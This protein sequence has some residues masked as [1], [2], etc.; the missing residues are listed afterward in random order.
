MET[1]KIAIKHYI[2]MPKSVTVN[3]NVYKFIPRNNISLAMVDIDDADTV[4][5]ITK[6]CCGG[7][8]KKIFRPAFPHDVRRWEQGGR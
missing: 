7:S 6:T 5:N 4:L 1:E 2:C 8:K 3:G